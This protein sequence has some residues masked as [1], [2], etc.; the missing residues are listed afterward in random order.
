ML[1][2]LYDQIT[3]AYALIDGGQLTKMDFTNAMSGSQKPN[4][5]RFVF[6]HTLTRKMHLVL[7]LFRCRSALS[8]G[9]LRPCIPSCKLYMPAAAY[10][11]DP[12]AVTN[13][14]R[15]IA[16]SIPPACEA[17]TC[18]VALHNNYTGQIRGHEVPRLES[19]ACIKARKY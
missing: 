3:T 8:M 9:V 5:K 13:Y 10:K 2:N 4:T 14:N 11:K 1:R 6:N 7:D 16:G 12:L 19:S 17:I 18:I 15:C